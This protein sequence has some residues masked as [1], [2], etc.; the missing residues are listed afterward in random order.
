MPA[1]K[2]LPPKKT[3]GKKPEPFSPP[4][5]AVEMNIRKRLQH[6]PVGS[7]QTLGYGANVMVKTRDLGGSAPSDTVIEQMKRGRP[8]RNPQ[9][10]K[11]S[12]AV[13]AAPSAV[14]EGLMGLGRGPTKAPAM[15]AKGQAAAA[16]LAA[17]K[18]KKRGS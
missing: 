18:K 3:A 4:R 14:M 2:P 5:R 15:G 6:R 8:I 9:A 11:L 12:T 17:Q 7:R 1:K 13:E 10:P 16:K